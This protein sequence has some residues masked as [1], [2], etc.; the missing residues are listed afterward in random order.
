[1]GFELGIG[2]KRIN[3]VRVSMGKHAENGP[4]LDL[5]MR[6]THLHADHRSVRAKA[7]DVEIEICEGKPSV[8]AR[9]SQTMHAR[10]AP[11]RI[12]VER[13]KEPWRM[14]VAVGN[15]AMFALAY[16]RDGRS[17]NLDLGKEALDVNARFDPQVKSHR[18]RRALTHLHVPYKDGA[19]NVSFRV[20]C[21]F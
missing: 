17:I 2:E 20:A 21:Y 14:R 18:R 8:S 6:G 19:W 5:S 10:V 9:V 3:G 12:E 11:G 7:R 15:Q 13:E 1:M 16:K 4:R